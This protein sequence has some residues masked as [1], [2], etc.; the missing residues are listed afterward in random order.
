MTYQNAKQAI[1]EFLSNPP[2][3]D[4]QVMRQQGNI[5][6]ATTIRF[7]KERSVP[8]Y[9]LYLVG[10]EAE[11]GQQRT[12]I[13]F[14]QQDEAGL[15]QLAHFTGESEGHPL[16]KEERDTSQPWV[17]LGSFRGRGGTPFWAGGRVIDHGFGVARVR[18]IGSNGLVLEDQVEQGF[19]LF[20]TDQEIQRPGEAELYDHSGGLVG[21]Q[22]ALPVW[23][24]P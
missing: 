8:H 18:L 13:C 21:K 9:Q 6:K 1:S 19:V 3:T 15:W 5:A 14:V 2:S 4:V 23:P 20:L 16:T 22:V 17:Q 7:L 11:A 12:S 24:K 10:Y